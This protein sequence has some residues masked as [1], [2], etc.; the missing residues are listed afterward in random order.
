M[1]EIYAAREAREVTKGKETTEQERK[2]WTAAEREQ[3]TELR[4]D[5]N[6]D[7]KVLPLPTTET[8]PATK[9]KVVILPKTR[10][11]TATEPRTALKRAT[12]TQTKTQTKVLPATKAQTALQAQLKIATQTQTATKTALKIQ[13][14][15]G[16][17]LKT[18]KLTPIKIAPVIK[19]VPKPKPIFPDGKK[20][21]LEELTSEEKRGAIA[22]KQGIGWWVVL[23][24]KRN[25]FSI[26]KPEGV[27]ITEPTNRPGKTIQAITGKPFNLTADLGNKDIKITF[28]GR[29]RKGKIDFYNDPKRRTNLQIKLG[30]R[31]KNELKSE[32]RGKLYY[33]K[34]QNGTLVS[35]RP[36]G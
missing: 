2:L 13:L 24:D 16:T 35:R 15:T 27:T 3:V 11:F 10:P 31:R 12:Q 25:F 34:D 14:K 6:E 7:V 26:K 22:W 32:K 21:K 20:G 1:E 28:R 18:A 8:Q 4:R 17:G 33:T 9:T 36:L 30:T 5:L 29:G 23:P 19:P